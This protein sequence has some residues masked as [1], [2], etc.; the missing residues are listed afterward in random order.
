MLV[1]DVV[2]YMALKLNV[3]GKERERD[4][5]RKTKYKRYVYNVYSKLG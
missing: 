4:E 2:C 3:A 5:N 1:C